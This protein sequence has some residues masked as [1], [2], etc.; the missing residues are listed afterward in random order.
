MNVF[1]TEFVQSVVLTAC[2]KIHGIKIDLPK[3][4]KKMILGGI[5]AIAIAAFAV[6]NVNVNSQNDNLS[7]LMLANVEALASG[8]G[9]GNPC[10]GPKDPWC[11]CTNPN[12]CK[13]L[14][15]CQ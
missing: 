6:V 3:N 9:I 7:D 2:K 5:A 15:G 1:Q 8:E 4:H 11:H 13:D 10:T 12:N 14:Y